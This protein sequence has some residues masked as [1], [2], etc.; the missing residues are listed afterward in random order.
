VSCHGRVSMGQGALNNN[1]IIIKNQLDIY[2][3]L[4]R[5][6]KADH[7][8]VNTYRK[9]RMRLSSVCLEFRRCSPS[10]RKSRSELQPFRSGKVT[11]H[12][13]FLRADWLFKLMNNR[14][15]SGVET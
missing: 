12:H 1:D 15:D 7:I 11:S 6:N 8:P 3:L 9:D 5:I 13:A 2:C 10:L 14:L 4:H